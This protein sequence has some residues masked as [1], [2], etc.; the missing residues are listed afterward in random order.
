MS[1]EEIS[2]QIINEYRGDILLA[3][4]NDEMKANIKSLSQEDIDS[5]IEDDINR[6]GL[7]L[8]PEEGEL[9][10]GDYEYRISM[11]ETK[12]DDIKN[13]IKEILSSNE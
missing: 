1:K 4:K 11:I 8:E 12:I 6:R 2:N 9:F 13:K 7:K 3:L 10:I 5:L